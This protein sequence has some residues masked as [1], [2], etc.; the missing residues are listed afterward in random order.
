MAKLALPDPRSTHIGQ[1]VATS[2]LDAI[3]VEKAV[4]P[5]RQPSCTDGPHEG[6]RIE[7]AKCPVD[8]AGERVYA[9]LADFNRPREHTTGARTALLRAIWIKAA[10]PVTDALLRDQA[11]PLGGDPA[12][13][14]L[15]AARRRGLGAL[16]AAP[17]DFVDAAVGGITVKDH[18]AGLDRRAYI[19]IRAVEE[20]RL[21]TDLLALREVARNPPLALRI[22]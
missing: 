5:D 17:T 1:Y 12:G 22:L 11:E 16:T 2:R 19:G 10:E 3:V 18:R 15:L 21:T 4:A 13:K 14:N 6:H 7:L 20:T 9:A 8:A